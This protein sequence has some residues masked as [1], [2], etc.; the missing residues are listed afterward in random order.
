MFP[1]N[2]G[3]D[4]PAEVLGVLPAEPV[5]MI[6]LANQIISYAYSQKVGGPAGP[7]GGPHGVQRGQPSHV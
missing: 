2:G 1:G 3:S 6:Q 7:W 4:L 5:G